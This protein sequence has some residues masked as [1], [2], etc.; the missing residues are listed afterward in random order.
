M[1]GRLLKTDTSLSSPKISLGPVGESAASL[2]TYVETGAGGV[3]DTQN[4][5]NDDGGM[6]DGEDAIVLNRE[7]RIHLVRCR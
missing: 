3:R 6:V 7:I 4:G 1:N 2:E 5:G